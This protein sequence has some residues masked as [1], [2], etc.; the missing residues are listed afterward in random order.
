MW[1]FAWYDERDGTLLLSR[2]RFGEKPLYLWRREAGLY[3]ASEVKGLAA[4]AGS[5]G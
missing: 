5:R 2:D 1:A 3:F 4:L